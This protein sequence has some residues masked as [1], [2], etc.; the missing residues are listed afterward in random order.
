[1]K[2]KD[3]V[4][5]RILIYYNVFFNPVTITKGEKMIGIMIIKDLANMNLV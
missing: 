3:D 1:M 5:G 2:K 4:S